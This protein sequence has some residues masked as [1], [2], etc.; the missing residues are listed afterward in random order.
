MQMAKTSTFYQLLK[1]FFCLIL[2]FNS[3][4]FAMDYYNSS[5][6]QITLSYVLVDKTL[7]KNVVVELDSIVSL[8]GGV[9]STNYSVYDTV[10]QFLTVP[11]VKVGDLF[12]TNSKVTVGKIIS[13]ESW[14]SFTGSIPLDKSLVGTPCH[15]LEMKEKIKNTDVFGSTEFYPVHMLGEKS[16]ACQIVSKSDGFPVYSGNQSLRFELRAGDCSANWR[17]VTNDCANDRSRSEVEDK[18]ATYSSINKIITY[19]YMMFIPSQINFKPPRA[20][21]TVSQILMF[22]PNNY[23]G[24]AQLLI[25]DNKNL[26]LALTT[27]FQ[28]TRTPEEPVL[29]FEKPFDQWIKIRFDIKTTT[30]PNGYVRLTVND[31]F[32]HEQVRQTS[33]EEELDITLRLGLYNTGITRFKE[34][35]PTQII[36]YDEVVRT[37]K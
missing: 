26:L 7:Y 29:V 16:Y 10:S 2:L 19:E 15:S 9:V 11:V 5:N 13:V 31:K 27:D 32:I 21:L 37:I 25:D 4:A 36:Y 1:K 34:E 20:S 24:L 18:S 17:N 33:A 14:S 6:N 12:Y 23:V 3:S 22:T 30:S 8:Q 28:W 35:W